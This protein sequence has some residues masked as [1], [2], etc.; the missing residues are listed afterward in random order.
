LQELAES[1]E[2][3]DNGR[4]ILT[5]WRT[6][7]QLLDNAHQPLDPNMTDKELHMGKA[8]LAEQE[9]EGKNAWNDKVS[10][11]LEYLIYW[12]TMVINSQALEQ[13]AAN[14]RKIDNTL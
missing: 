4:N 13:R 6:I 8:S 5:A 10:I 11:D 14:T 12:K 2:I 7:R 9:E 1:L 3:F